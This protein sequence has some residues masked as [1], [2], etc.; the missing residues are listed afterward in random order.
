MSHPW[1]EFRFAVDLI[2]DGAVTPLKSC[3]SFLGE[4]L[5]DCGGGGP[6]LLPRAKVTLF[7]V[8]SCCWEAFCFCVPVAVFLA[9]DLLCVGSYL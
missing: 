1:Y 4:L 7:P 5:C 9:F 3:A 6:P 8:E 2:L